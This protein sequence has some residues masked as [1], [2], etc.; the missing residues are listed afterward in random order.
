MATTIQVVKSKMK[1]TD[2]MTGAMSWAAIANQVYSPS[3][4]HW[5]QIFDGA[6][7]EEVQRKLN[8]LRVKDSLV[9][10]LTQNEDAFFSSICLVMIP[11]DG[12]SLEEGKH[13][14][15]EPCSESNNM[16]GTLHIEDDVMLF[17][18]DGQHRKESIAE[19]IKEAPGLARE[20]VP[21]VLI[22]YTGKG[23]VRQ[24]FSDLNL[25]AKPVNKTIGQ[26]FEQRDPLVLACKRLL[27]DVPLFKDRV[28]Q[29]SNSLSAR[30]KEIVTLN[31]LYVS[32][33][34]I[35][36][37]IHNVPPRAVDVGKIT[38]IAS[39]HGEPVTSLQIETLAEPL[40]KVW[41][42]YLSNTPGWEDLVA[43]HTTA[44]A[45]RDGDT[46]TGEP[47]FVSAYGIGWQAAAKAYAAIVRSGLYTDPFAKFAKC[48]QAVN[49]QKGAHWNAIAMVG[50]R[51]NNTGPGIQATAGYI[52]K[53]G[54]VFSD[55]VNPDDRYINTLRSAYAKAT[56]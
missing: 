41:N 7:D 42:T 33:V 3:S 23:K 36:A 2:F 47:G 4:N 45:I 20:R 25:N 26:A 54:G 12:S 19:A 22:G 27:L 15:F 8:K 50:T 40:V 18:A 52:L 17:P 48:L 31:T 10:Y 51:V 44:G 53:E 24:L 9:P 16:I 13:Y 21:V 35:Y 49:W 34:D 28:N 6:G 56:S 29:R 14:R 43:G 5:D 32:S 30:S 46:L 55:P 1:G 11:L 39:C 37:A 38:E